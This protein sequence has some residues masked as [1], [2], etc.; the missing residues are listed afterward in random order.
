MRMYSPNLCSKAATVNLY[1][2]NGGSWTSFKLHVCLFRESNI[3]FPL[4]HASG[5]YWI[6]SSFVW[7]ILVFGVF[8]VVWF[9]VLFGFGF[10]FLFFG[11]FIW[12]GECLVV[13]FGFSFCVW[14]R[15][16]TKVSVKRRFHLSFN[17]W[18]KLEENTSGERI[19]FGFTSSAF[20]LND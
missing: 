2:C 9:L 13:W 15:Q 17:N 10:L 14:K 7:G 19:I 12:G 3:H 5:V 18:I 8:F 4:K 16:C 11:V 6:C 20:L 1:I